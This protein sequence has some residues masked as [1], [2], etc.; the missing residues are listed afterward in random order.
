[1]RAD[2]TSVTIRIKYTYARAYIIKDYY[3]KEIKANGWDASISAPSMIKGS[4]CGENRYVGVLNILEFHLR[5]N[6]T[7]NIEP[8]D[9][10][11][12]SIRLNWTM[13]EFFADGGTTKFADRL[14]ASLGIKAANI[15]IVSVY[16]GSVIVDSQILE[17]SEGTLQKSGGIDQVSTALSTK[18]SSGNVNLGAEILSV[19]VKTTKAT[20]KATATDSAAP[21]KIVVGSPDVNTKTDGASTNSTNGGKTVITPIIKTNVTTVYSIESAGS[22]GNDG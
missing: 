15:K 16:M 3:G 19:S 8:I 2:Y 7:I 14:A 13:N 11:Q 10:I 1:M 6:C 9:S 4:F 12:T 18:L 5:K 22:V 20:A 17:D 21:P